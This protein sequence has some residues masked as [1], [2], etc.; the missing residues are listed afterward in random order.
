MTP[1]LDPQEDSEGAFRSC[2]PG[3]CTCLWPRTFESHCGE[4]QVPPNLP[5]QQWEGRSRGPREGGVLT[6]GLV[7]VDADALQL[8][9][10]VP[11][12]VAT[13]VYSV[14]IADDLPELQGKR[15]QQGPWQA[16]PQS[17]Q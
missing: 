15:S 7:V 1:A 3:L 13:R 4:S 14:L 6:G 2:P 10:R 17:L 16:W 5:A 8:Q 9:V 12:V 11:H